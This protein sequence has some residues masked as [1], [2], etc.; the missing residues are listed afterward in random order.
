MSGKSRLPSGEPRRASQRHSRRGVHV[1]VAIE[2]EWRPG[3][4]VHWRGYTGSF[5]RD[6]DDGQAAILIGTR[7][8]LVHKAEL[9]SGGA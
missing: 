1:P 8:Y 7:T 9:R 6:A 3:D 2:P 5:L 4:R